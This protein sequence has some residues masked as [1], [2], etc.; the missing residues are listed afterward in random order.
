MRWVALACQNVL[1]CN[2]FAE[3]NAV[4]ETPVIPVGIGV[5]AAVELASTKCLLDFSTCE[6]LRRFWFT[7]LS[8]TSVIIAAFSGAVQ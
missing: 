8:G 2:C 1:R 5:S 6:A 3:P 4:S 7:A